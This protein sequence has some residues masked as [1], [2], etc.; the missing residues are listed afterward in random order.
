VVSKR[1]EA[2]TKEKSAVLEDLKKKDFEVIS[3]K[4]PFGPR[5]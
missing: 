4:I 3:K 1:V 5:N 2:F